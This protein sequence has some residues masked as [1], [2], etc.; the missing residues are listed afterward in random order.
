MRRSAR[1]SGAI[2]QSSSAQTTAPMASC[3]GRSTWMSAHSPSASIA[4]AA[5]NVDGRIS[6][7][8]FTRHLARQS[9]KRQRTYTSDRMKIFDLTGKTAVVTGAA[10]GIG[11][12]TADLLEKAGAA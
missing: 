5:S 7:I 3:P 1:G 10:R 4:I 8:D 12:A 2:R 11:K 6:A 9:I